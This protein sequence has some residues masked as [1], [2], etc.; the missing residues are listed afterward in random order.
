MFPVSA[1]TK[2]VHNKVLKP[3]FAIGRFTIDVRINSGGL[4]EANSGQP[5]VNRKSDAGHRARGTFLRLAFW[6]A[7]YHTSGSKKFASNPSRYF[8]ARNMNRTQIWVGSLSL[9]TASTHR[10]GL[11]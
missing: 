6:K 5:D 9:I 2:Y 7:S 3:T 8:R 1:F 4:A 11:P 10:T